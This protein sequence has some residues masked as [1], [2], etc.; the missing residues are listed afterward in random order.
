M[1]YYTGASK[2]VYSVRLH[3]SFHGRT[4]KEIALRVFEHSHGLLH[5]WGFQLH[6]PD[7]KMRTVLCPGPALTY[8]MGARAFV[9]A[10]DSEAVKKLKGELRACASPL[11]DG[12]VS[13]LGKTGGCGASPVPSNVGTI[14]KFPSV[15]EVGSIRTLQGSYRM[16]NSSR[17]NTH[18]LPPTLPKLQA[19]PVSAS[20]V[21]NSSPIRSKTSPSL[22]NL[23][24]SDSMLSPLDVSATIPESKS[25][26]NLPSE[27]PGHGTLV[28]AGSFTSELALHKMFTFR[29]RLKL[30]VEQD[31]MYELVRRKLSKLPTEPPSSVS[32]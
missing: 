12:S 20:P 10:P 15:S 32:A 2:E 8:Q 17:F 9:I 21:L 23:D 16:G 11:P 4:F 1:E 7:G 3:D 25:V 18:Q 19:I 22:V 28:K 31:L 6:S 27:P 26:G 29:K 24:K 30:D 14:R 13:Q 5:L